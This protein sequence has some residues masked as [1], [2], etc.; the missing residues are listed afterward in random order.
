MRTARA[1]ECEPEAAGEEPYVQRRLFFARV[2]S[3]TAAT[4]F[5]AGQPIPVESVRTDVIPAV[6]DGV[7][8]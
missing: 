8:T 1:A 4:R 3:T 2:T 5:L 7:A 6:M